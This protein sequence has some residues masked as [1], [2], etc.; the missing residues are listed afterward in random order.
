MPSRYCVPALRRPQIGEARAAESRADFIHKLDIALKGLNETQVW[1][2]MIAQ[3]K[4]ASLVNPGMT[5]DE[6]QQLARLLNA[7]VQ[8]A[9]RNGR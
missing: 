7:S 6:C 1:L 4:L 2:K 9:R 5:L 8:T 3:A